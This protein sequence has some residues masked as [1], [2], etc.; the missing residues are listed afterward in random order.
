MKGT[1]N[2][3]RSEHENG[4]NSLRLIATLAVLFSH[5]FALYGLREPQPLAG[6]TYG[7]LA[8][9]M[10][11]SLSGF[12]VC[13]SWER[14]PHWLRFALRRALRILPGLAIAVIIT[15]LLIG[16]IFTTLSSADYFSSSA[17]WRYVVRGTL[18][19]GSPQLPGVFESNPYPYVTNA[20]LWTLTYEVLMYLILALI[21]HWFKNA[22]LRPACTAAFFLF[23][24]TWVTLQL[25]GWSDLQFPFAARLGIDVNV[26]RVAHLGA[27]FFA[28]AC[29][30]LF[31]AHIYVSR[32]L[33]AVLICALVVVSNSTATLVALWFIAPYAMNIFAFKC[34]KLFRTVNGYDL[35]YGIYI[36]AFP[37]QQMLSQIGS[38]RGWSWALVLFASTL[39]TVVVAAL[40]WYLVEKP[41]LALKDYLIGKRVAI[42]NQKI[43][44]FLAK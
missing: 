5:S 41:A 43:G 40:S 4:F 25:L 6:Q 22:H 21:G 9:A 13:Q 8:V 16:P 17:V 20:S 3:P 27:L 29:S 12:L 14:D 23:A 19:L 10:F 36:Y 2:L 11:F 34:P 37:I 35:S 18:V 32:I 30:Y 39:S 31:R 28:G 33:A 44:G 1:P 7:N 15:A 38:Q 26:S 24:A 42:T